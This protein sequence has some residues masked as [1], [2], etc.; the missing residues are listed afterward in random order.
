MNYPY[1]TTYQGLSRIAMGFKSAQSAVNL[2]KSNPLRIFG[3]GSRAIV[4]CYKE[5]WAECG[6]A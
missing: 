1:L 6:A 3:N 2:V 5:I 4:W